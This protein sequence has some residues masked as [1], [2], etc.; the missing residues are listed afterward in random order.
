M[1]GILLKIGRHELVQNIK[2]FIEEKSGLAV[3]KR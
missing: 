3:G 2:Q 1:K